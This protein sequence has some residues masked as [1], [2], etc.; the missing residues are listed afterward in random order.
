MG[1]G[2]GRWLPV[3]GA[4]QALEPRAQGDTAQDLAFPPRQAEAKRA[5]NSKDVPATGPLKLCR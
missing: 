5:Q 3:E 4:A 1:E 2:L